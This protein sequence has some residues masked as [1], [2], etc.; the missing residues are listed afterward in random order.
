MAV[1]PPSAITVALDLSHRLGWEFWLYD[2][3]AITRDVLLELHPGGSPM[4]DDSPQHLSNE[5]KKE[6]KKALE[7]KRKAMDLPKPDPKEHEAL[8]K[9]WTLYWN[10]KRMETVAVGVRG[11]EVLIAVNVKKRITARGIETGKDELPPENLGLH[12]GRHDAMIR[13]ACVQYN[14]ENNVN[15]K[16][17]LLLP[18]RQPETKEQNSERH[19]EMQI[20]AYVRQQNPGG[21]GAWGIEAIGVSKPLCRS[22]LSFVKIK[23][24]PYAAN[25]R[26]YL[27][28]PTVTE[29]KGI[30]ERAQ[31]SAEQAQK[32]A[33]NLDACRAQVRADS[34]KASAA[35]AKYEAAV[36][37]WEAALDDPSEE[38]KLRKAMNQ[39]KGARIT[40]QNKLAAST[41]KMN[42]ARGEKE[43]ADERSRVASERANMVN[44]R[45]E[46]FN[47][48]VPP[49]HWLDPKSIQ[50]GRMSARPILQPN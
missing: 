5:I 47:L 32:A 29:V 42:N 15:Y 7:E 39:A 12:D 50:F 36:R 1:A 37:A 9:W 49:G 2:H 35:T 27:N 46:D 4:G 31:K 25:P 34:A 23:K 14:E 8:N 45:P 16:Y 19:A 20:Y 22:C 6:A 17:T 26:Y 10:E 13:A 21:T 43:K 33:S 48:D 41:T 38:V 24:I 18:E 30:V 40:A 11:N 44:T 3:G 28:E